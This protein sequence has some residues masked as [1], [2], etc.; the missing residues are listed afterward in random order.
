MFPKLLENQGSTHLH[1]KA[2]RACAAPV[3]LPKRPNPTLS[4]AW[5]TD[6]FGGR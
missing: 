6:S 5:S 2:V 3:A 1:D 4:K